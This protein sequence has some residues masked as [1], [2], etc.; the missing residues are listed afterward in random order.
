MPFKTCA[1]TDSSHVKVFEHVWNEFF[2]MNLTSSC[3]S[4]LRENGIIERGNF[5]FFVLINVS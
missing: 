2:H 5:R 4:K 3:M 1:Y